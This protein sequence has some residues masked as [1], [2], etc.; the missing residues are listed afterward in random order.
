MAIGDS[1]VL[2]EVETA[3]GEGAVGE[4]GVAD[5]AR[6]CWLHRQGTEE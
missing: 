4:F 2:T 1:P 5:E 3:Q 6:D